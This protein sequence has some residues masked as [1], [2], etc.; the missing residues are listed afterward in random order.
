MVVL[1]ILLFSLFFLSGCVSIN[2]SMSPQQDVVYTFEYSVSTEQ[3]YRLSRLWI[4]DT[5]NSAKDVITFEDAVLNIITG[6]FN[7]TAFL[8]GTYW[9]NFKI[10]LNA[11]TLTFSNFTV[12]GNRM[13]EGGMN[14]IRENLDSLANSY[15]QAI[16]P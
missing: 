12:N 14:N 10:D 4:A 6:R 2:N 11:H 13:Y 9:G 8:G 3:A 1:E 5:F 7:F 15:K 16:N